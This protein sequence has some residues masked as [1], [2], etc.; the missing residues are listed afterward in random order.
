MAGRVTRPTRTRYAVLFFVYLA[1]F[2]TYLDRVCISVAAPAMQ[3]DLGL[4][5][6]QFAWV[7]T[8]FYIAYGVCEMPTAWLGDRWGQRRMLIR[9]VGCWSLFTI[10]TGMVRN[11]ATLMTTRFVFGA[12][13]AGAFPTLSRALSRWF[14][15]GERSRANGIM[16]MG[17]RSGG[18]VAPPIAAAIIALVGWRYAFAMFGLLGLIWT[19]GC[20]FWFREEPADHPS[21]NSEELRVIRLGAAPPPQ[22]G[23]RVPW[24]MLLFNPTMVALFCSYFASG[25]GFQ[26]FVT[27]LPTYLIREHGSTLQQ[28]G[29]LSGLPLA[30]GA[31]GCLVGGVVADWITRR[32]GSVTIGRRTVGVS[33]FLLAA[34]GY[35]GAMYGH[36]A[37]AVIALLA[38]ASGAHDMTLPVLWATTTDAGGRFGGTASGFV[39]LASSLSGTL[40]P[41]TAALLERTFGSFHAV[42]LVAAALYLSGAALW[43]VIDPRRPALM[44]KDAYES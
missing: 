1:A 35:A 14:P 36:S 16:W 2:I 33:G 26:F 18:A 37:A 27:W 31:V 6:I 43:L 15:L 8:V 39:N 13:E 23:E 30:A 32:T 40:A 21:V 4:S 7:F 3:H 17:A 34:A 24:K 20:V 41:M 28:S 29:V 5:Q 11:L 12:A 38:L 22:A 25:F 19:A 9:I 10:L 42:F 44:E